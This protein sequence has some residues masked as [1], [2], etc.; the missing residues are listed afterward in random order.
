MRVKAVIV[1]VKLTKNFSSKVFLREINFESSLYPLITK[2][3]ASLYV[4]MRIIKNR[5]I[6]IISKSSLMDAIMISKKI[7]MLVPRVKEKENSSAKEFHLVLK[8]FNTYLP[9]DTKD[10]NTNRSVNIF[11]VTSNR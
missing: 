10:S 1:N 6:I 9:K 11:K 5:K 8:C 2:Y 3:F 7:K 4:K